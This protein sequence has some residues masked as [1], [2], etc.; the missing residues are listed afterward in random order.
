MYIYTYCKYRNIIMRKLSNDAMHV[1]KIDF[2][3]L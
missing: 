2:A 1:C 3:I